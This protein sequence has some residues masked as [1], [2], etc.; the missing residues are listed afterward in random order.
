MMASSTMRSP[1]RLSCSE[2]LR[3]KASPAPTATGRNHKGIIVGTL[4]GVIA[5]TTPTGWRI[6]AM[7]RWARSAAK[8]TVAVLRMCLG[9]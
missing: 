8:V 2:D 6:I 7:L 5:A 9:V 4:N 3:M 1:A